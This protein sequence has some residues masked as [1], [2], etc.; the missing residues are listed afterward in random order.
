[1]R[2]SVR[3]FACKVKHLFPQT[4]VRFIVDS[5]RLF[6][7]HYV[8]LFVEQAIVS[9]TTQPTS[10]T[11]LS[12]EKRMTATVFAGAGFADNLVVASSGEFAVRFGDT[13]PCHAVYVR[14]RLVVGLVFVVLCSLVG[15][16]ASSVLADRGAVPASSPAVRPALGAI[17]PAPTPLVADPASVYI[18][19]PG[20]TMWVIAQHFRSAG[21]VP[22]YVES[23]IDANG[24]TTALQIGQALTLP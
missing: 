6:V 20:D 1:M 4:F 13:R 5:E 15:F 17:P 22:A 21:D 9:P 19:Q 7:A 8:R 16:T 18:V 24:G 3:M 23:L 10:P 2:V 14:R 11:K 12:R